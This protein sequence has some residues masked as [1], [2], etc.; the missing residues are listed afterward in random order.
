MGGGSVSLDHDFVTDLAQFHRT[1]AHREEYFQS[2]QRL[3]LAGV[4]NWQL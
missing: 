2:L 1:P 3:L 4:T